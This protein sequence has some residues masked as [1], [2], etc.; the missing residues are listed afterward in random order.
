MHRMLMSIAGVDAKCRS[1]LEIS[2]RLDNVAGH[3]ISYHAPLS[4]VIV[5]STSKGLVYSLV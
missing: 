5:P 4:F 1:A 2:S 3:Q